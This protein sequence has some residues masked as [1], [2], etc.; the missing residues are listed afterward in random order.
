VENPLSKGIKELRKILK[1]ER[2]NR[3][4]TVKKRKYKTKETCKYTGK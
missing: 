2:L 1:R 3:K 4:T